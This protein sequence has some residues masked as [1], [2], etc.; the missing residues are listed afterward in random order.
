M[1]TALEAPQ[2]QSASF[3][4]PNGFVF[5]LGGRVFRAVDRACLGIIRELQQSGLLERLVDD[6]MVVVTEIVED[7]ALLRRMHEAYPGVY[8]FLEHRSITPISY[9]YEWSTSMLADAGILTLDLQMRLLE[10]GYSLKDATAYNIQFV[11]GRPVF[12]DIPSIERPRRLDIWPA[13]GQFNRMF[14]HALLL[15]ER[16]GQTLRSYFLANIDGSGIPQVRRAFGRLELLKPGLLLDLTIPYLLER[17]A[18]SILRGLPRSLAAAQTS[19][20][21]QIFNLKRLRSKLRGFSLRHR[22]SGAWTDYTETCSY[23]ERAHQSK[24]AS[25]RRFVQEYRPAT[26][27]DLGCNTGFYAQLAVKTGCRVVAVDSDPESV[28]ILYRQVRANRAPILPLCIDITNPSPAI[29]FRNRERSSF[30][31]RMKVD[32]VFVLALIHHLHVQGN[33][34]LA[35]IRDMLAD[36]TK[37]FLVL[38]F[39][40]SNDAMFRRLMDYR[41]EDFSAYTVESCMGIFDERFELISRECVEDSPRTLL[42]YRRR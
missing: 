29:G 35:G 20:E 12:I 7:E 34:P 14:T 22:V 18:G 38:E 39:I 36:I 8:G 1:T 21:A 3:R 37:E 28:E 24:T 15:N 30:L 23:S 17:R 25:I 40:P 27:L 16:K 10:H 33:L 5:E 19:P 4:D 41:T 6:G 9:P 26:V 11:D 32:C 31:D 42:F 13:L 2:R